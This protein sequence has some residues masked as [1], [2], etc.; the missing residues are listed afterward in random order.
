MSS[1]REEKIYING[2]ELESQD[3]KWLEVENPSKKGTLAG[4]V[5]RATADDV[6]KAVKAAHEAFKTWGKTNARERSAL[7]LKVADELEKIKEDIA[8][9]I[10][11]ENG[12]ALRTQA[13][14]EAVG[15]V[16]L[17][18]YYAGLATELKGVTYQG[19][20]NLFLYSYRAPV[21]VVAAVVPWNAPVQ[22]SAGKLASSLIAGNTIILKVASDAPMAAMMMAKTVARLLPA[23]VVNVLSGPG[24]ACGNALVSHPLVNKISLTGSTQVGKDVMKLAADRIVNSTME[25]GGKNPQIVFADCDVDK[26]VPG[27]LMATRVTRQ[28]QSCTSGANI[29]IQREIFDETV[30]KLAAAAEKLKVG[31]ACDEA[32]DMGAVTNKAQYSGIMGYIEKAMQE[33]DTKLITGGLPPSEGPLSEGYFLVPTIFTSKGNTSVLAKEEVFGPVMVCIP[34]D[35]ED[36]AIALANE[37]EYGLAAFVWSKDTAR[38]M[39]VAHQIDAGWTLVNYGGGQVMGQPYGGMKESGLGREYCLEGVLESF[40]ELKSVIM[41]MSYTK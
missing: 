4:R 14:G 11:L 2:Q 34:F 18:R 26:T 15:A 38:A 3:G 16:D 39:R 17:F 19:P 24:S 37:T 5:P 33:P 27:L 30:K 41:D 35:S 9:T 8:Y 40:T 12:N 22:L 21:G 32:N 36:E 1:L 6:D 31:D 25:L 28:G 23:G 20:D 13:R 10:A 29:Y 7:L